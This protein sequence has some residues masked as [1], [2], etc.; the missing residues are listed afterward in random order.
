MRAIA[1]LLLLLA[2]LH[3]AGAV[4]VNLMVSPGVLAHLLSLGVAFLQRIFPRAAHLILRALRKARRCQG[5][6]RNPQGKRRSHVFVHT[7]HD[8]LLSRPTNR[9]NARSVGA[10]ALHRC[11]PAG[12]KPW[13]RLQ[14]RHRRGESVKCITGE[15]AELIAARTVDAGKLVPQGGFE[16]STYRLRSDCSTVELLRRRERC[17]KE[18]ARCR[19]GAPSPLRSSPRKWGP[20]ITDCG[21]WIPACA[22][23]NG[24]G[25]CLSTRRALSPFVPAKAGTQGWSWRL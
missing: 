8:T 19:S 14:N 15:E 17:S 5:G 1:A 2:V 11:K 25:I 21:P 22:G 7:D 10:A 18:A 9:D 3:H 12:R 6:N 23:M 16:P 24:R 4:F 13:E 20:R